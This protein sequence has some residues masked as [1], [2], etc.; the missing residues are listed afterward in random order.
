MAKIIVVGGIKGG[1]GKTTIATNLVTIFAQDNK[2]LLVDADE[3]KS[4]C[5]WAAQREG[6][7]PEA[8]RFTT[9]CLYNRSVFYEIEKMQ[10]DYDTIIVDVGGRDTT[11][12][13]AA[14]AIADIFLVPFRPRIYDVWT[15]GILKNLINDIKIINKKMVTLAFLNQADYSGTDNIESIAFI[16]ECEDVVCF[17]SPVAARKAFPNAASDGLGVI[18]AK[19]KDEKAVSEILSL[20]DYIKEALVNIH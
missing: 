14:L 17:R 20:A 5:D 11:S 8:S 1:C 19:H 18:E 6:L 15:L 9:V 10:A 4:A 16:E 13:R 2:V 7:S 3:Q 12:Q